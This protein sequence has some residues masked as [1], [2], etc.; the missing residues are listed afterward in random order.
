MADAFVSEV[1][2]IERDGHVATVWLDRP[3]ARNAMGRVFWDD[4]VRAMADVSD[5][6]DV[7]AVV[8]AA[9]GPHFSVGL[10]LKE[11]GS[12]LSGGAG[13]GSGPRPSMAAR[14]RTARA[15]VLKLQHS[16]NVVAA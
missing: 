8:L 4:L 15:A 13:S 9:R 10:D 1:L 16:I 11:M 7:R 5:D 2:S 6:P 14:A 12:V 3:D